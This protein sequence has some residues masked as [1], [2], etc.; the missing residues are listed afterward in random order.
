VHSTLN[1][2]GGNVA[3]D[4]VRLTTPLVTSPGPRSRNLLLRE[5]LIDEHFSELLSTQCHAV[6]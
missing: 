3:A 6:R 5:I 1:Q 2:P 4:L